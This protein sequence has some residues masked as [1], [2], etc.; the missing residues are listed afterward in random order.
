MADDADAAATPNRHRG[1]IGLT[2]S[3][4]KLVMRPDF[5]AVAAIDE[6]LGSIVGLTRRAI[7]QPESLSLHELAV[8]VTEGVR[9]HGRANKTSEAHSKLEK[10]KRMIFETGIPVAVAPVCQF[11]GQAVTGGAEGN[12]PAPEA[13]PS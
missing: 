5:E 12:D 10:I 4:M 1:E 8:I 3:G 6:Q 7:G 9:A 11:L 2:L 13:S